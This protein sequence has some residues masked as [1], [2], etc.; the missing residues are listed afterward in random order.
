M[1]ELE[2]TILLPVLWD[3]KLNGQYQLQCIVEAV[4]YS[5]NIF[6]DYTVSHPRREYFL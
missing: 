4:V 3:V 1:W 6:P 2:I 5:D